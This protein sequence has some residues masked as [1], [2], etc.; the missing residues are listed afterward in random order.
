MGIII[1]NAVAALVLV[2]SLVLDRRKTFQGLMVG[3]QVL[4]GML[5][6]IIVIVVLVGL[7]LGFVPE[8]LLASTIGGKGGVLGLIIAAVFGSLVAIPSPAIFPLAVSMLGLA[9]TQAGFFAV[10]TVGCFIT[11]NSMVGCVSFP[12]EL[13]IMGSRAA[14]IRLSLSFVAAVSIALLMG[15]ILNGY[16][17]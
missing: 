10:A 16:H 8:N 2:I 9:G 13:N 14:W 7:L 12:I 1:L 15:V 5:A 3:L 6:L 11:T 17:V 4:K